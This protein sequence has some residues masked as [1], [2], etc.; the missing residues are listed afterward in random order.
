M[1]AG[2]QAQK[3]A[4]VDEDH[5]RRVR[6]P[7]D[8][9]VADAGL[10]PSDAGTQAPA[11]A[12]A[13]GAVTV[14]VGNR[15]FRVG[16]V[17]LRGGAD[18]DVRLNEGLFTGIETK[19]V[20]D[21]KQRLKKRVADK[22]LSPKQRSR[23]EKELN[24][25]VASQPSDQQHVLVHD[26]RLAYELDHSDPFDPFRWSKLQDVVEHGQLDIFATNGRF[27]ARHP[28]RYLHPGP[29]VPKDLDTLRPPADGIALPRL[30]IARKMWYLERQA[31]FDIDQFTPASNVDNRDQIFYKV[32]SVLSS[33]VPGNALAHELFGHIW[34]LQQGVPWVHSD[35]TD[36]T[37]TGNKRAVALMEGTLRAEHRVLDPFDSL[38]EGTVEDF[39]EHYAGASINVIFSPTHFVSSMHLVQVLDDLHR[40]LIPT[41]M[42]RN[43]E[44]RAVFLSE[45]LIS[46]AH[47]SNNYRILSYRPEAD[48]HKRKE[49]VLQKIVEQWFRKEFDANQQTWFREFVKTATGFGVGIP[50]E[51]R[52]AII[53]EIGPR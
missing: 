53:A 8:A 5:Q 12:E 22:Q 29:P 28:D 9:G 26:G 40:Q 35:L 51:L 42:G 41:K 17:V 11:P 50:H 45:Q 48:P 46:F 24:E 20:A 49:N 31:G 23:A 10:S 13:G 52:D 15:S 36:K 18:V 47:L 34:L 39:I 16:D 43:K 30:E 25:L 21:A 44:G 7:A 19:E 6:N 14:M 32:R 3:Q 33:L 2:S 38:F 1:D 27:T 4:F 37:L